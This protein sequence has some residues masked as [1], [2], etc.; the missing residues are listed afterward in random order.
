M[1]EVAVAAAADCP[2]AAASASFLTFWSLNQVMRT[3]L[4]PHADRLFGRPGNP[5]RSIE[6]LGVFVNHATTMV[7]VIITGFCAARM[8]YQEDGL[9]LLYSNPLYGELRVMP[10]LYPFSFGY[11]CYDTL[12]LF[13]TYR[14]KAR[15]SPPHWCARIP[16]S[17]SASSNSQR[18][19]A[20]LLLNRMLVHHVALLGGGLFS[21]AIGNDL[22]A[23]EFSVGHCAAQP[24][25]ML[26]YTNEFN[27][28][29]ML[30]RV[31]TTI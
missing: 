11:V 15:S 4:R 2:L 23:G 27:S 7:H 25:V 22:M 30:N 28:L 13:R 18:R 20:P 5:G 12:D 8:L 21:C 29:F 9:A 19:L 26:L 24:L 1:I 17:W 16:R 6:Q 10:F 3:I 14:S 31:R